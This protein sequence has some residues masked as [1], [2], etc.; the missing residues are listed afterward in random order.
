MAISGGDGS[1]ILTT[2]ID[3]S[4]L[5]SGLS[6]LKSGVGA[7]GKA[8]AKAGAAGAAAFASA[9]V[10]AIKLGADFEQS[11]AKA[12]TL[13]GDVAVDTDNLNKKM[14]E[15]SSSTGVAATE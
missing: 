1:I 6:K 12:S 4:G 7:F 13:F 2:K 11:A 10:A 15:L 3:E 8:F 5:N 9:G 14:L